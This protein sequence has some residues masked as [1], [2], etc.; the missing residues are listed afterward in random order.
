TVHAHARVHAYDHEVELRQVL[1][2]QVEA[3][4]AQDV[5]LH[6]LEDLDAF[7]L[8]AHGIDLL[9]LPFEALGGH[10][11]R[12]ARGPAVVGDGH[13]PVAPSLAGARHGFDRVL[14][15]APGGVHLEVAADVAEL[16]ELRQPALLR[17]LDLAAILPQLGRDPW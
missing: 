2:R 6:A 8:A 7:D 14:A 15:I 17:G 9:P 3:A 1:I 4:V 10:T 12:D 5:H 13:V 11:V 16:E